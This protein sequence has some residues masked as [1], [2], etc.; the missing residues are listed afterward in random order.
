MTTRDKT[1]RGKAGQAGTKSDTTGQK[2]VESMRKTRAGAA[3]A[4]RPK[5]PAASRRGASTGHERV[6]AST[7]AYQ[8]GRRVWPD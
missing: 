7:D 6:P 3:A 4:G 1:A 5:K 8:F 2:L